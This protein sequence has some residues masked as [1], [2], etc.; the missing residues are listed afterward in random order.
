MRFKSACNLYKERENRLVGQRLRTAIR[1]S[2]AARFLVVIGK[3]ANWTVTTTHIIDLR[4]T[5]SNKVIY[6]VI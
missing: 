1:R 4:W 3:A 6:N 2:M 5:F